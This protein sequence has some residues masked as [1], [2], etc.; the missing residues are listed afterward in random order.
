MKRSVLEHTNSSWH[1]SIHQ[2]IQLVSI[3]ISHSAYK[4]FFLPSFKTQN[5]QPRCQQLGYQQLRCQQI[6]CQQPRYPYLRCQHPRCKWLR[7]QQSKNQ[8]PR[9]NSQGISVLTVS[10]P[11]V[12]SQQCCRTA[13]GKQIS[14]FCRNGFWLRPKRK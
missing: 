7:H 6:R 2:S 11:D 5:Q 10:S 12:R 4:K 14:L 9:C 13:E 8:Q 1:L 3:L